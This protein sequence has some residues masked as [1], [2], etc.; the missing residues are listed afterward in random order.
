VLAIPSIITSIDL[1][2]ETNRKL[3]TIMPAKELVLENYKNLPSNYINTGY[4]SNREITNPDFKLVS[5]ND[6]TKLL[7]YE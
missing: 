4:N 5:N 3:E 7:V 1:T 6:I 2:V